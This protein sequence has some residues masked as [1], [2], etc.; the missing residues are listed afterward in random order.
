MYDM[1][2]QYTIKVQDESEES[3]EQEATAPEDQVA[4]SDDLSTQDTLVSLLGAVKTLTA[5]L[6][7]VKANNKHLRALVKE[8]QET[9][10]SSASPPPRTDG[11][12]ASAKVSQPARAVTLPELCAMANLSQKADRRVAQL[13][14]ADTSES[15]S[16]SDCKD[17]EMQE[18]SQEGSQ[19]GQAFDRLVSHS[20]L[21]WRPKL[22][23]L[24]CTHSHGHIVISGHRDVKYD[25]LITL[26]EFV[27]SYGQ[28]LQSPDLLEVERCSRLQHLVSLIN[29]FCTDL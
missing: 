24:S 7:E 11:A 20:S 14:L 6:D 3:P 28:I 13:G 29:V 8:K 21:G 16:D 5:G 17:S 12:G 25:E 27:A 2:S 23:A 18:G 10:G 26:E 1:T 22:P 9:E 4:L 19:E 15:S